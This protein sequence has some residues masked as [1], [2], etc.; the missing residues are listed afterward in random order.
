MIADQA[1]ITADY[2]KRTNADLGILKRG[3]GWLKDKLEE[4]KKEQ[5]QEEVS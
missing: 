3:F 2:T 5:K 4:I 1:K